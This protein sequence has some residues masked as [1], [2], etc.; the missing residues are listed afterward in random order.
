MKRVATA[1]AVVAVLAVAWWWMRFD[2]AVPEVEARA[3]GGESA[4]PHAGARREGAAV[5][6]SDAAAVAVE[7]SGPG[8]EALLAL[9]RGTELSLYRCALPAEV[10]EVQMYGLPVVQEGG[11]VSFTWAGAGEAALH[12]ANPPDRPT[13]DRDVEFED[14]SYRPPPGAY[15]AYVDELDAYRED[16]ESPRA[17][18]RWDEVAPGQVGRCEVTLPGALVDVQVSVVDADQ[19]PIEGASVSSPLPSSVPRRSDARGQAT[20]Q[21]HEGVQSWFSAMAILEDEVLSGHTESRS[22]A[23]VIVVEPHDNEP[24]E[25]PDLGRY[26]RAME[27]VSED[28]ASLLAEWRDAEA[29]MHDT[30]AD[31]QALF[32]DYV[33]QERGE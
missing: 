27:G 12:G 29:R 14:G 2:R 17:Y 3:T 9:A 32:E 4:K 25:A 11:V 10:G 28:A 26:D 31:G 7:P 16:W 5:E 23:V 6:L 13:L 22:G 21:V 30:I 1:V 19:N 20:V 33:A 18:L 15:E 8:E 24:P